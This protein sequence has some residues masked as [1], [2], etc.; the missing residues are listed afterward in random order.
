[1]KKWISLLLCGTLVL[2]SFLAAGT[3]YNNQ[4]SIPTSKNAYVPI[5]FGINIDVHNDGTYACEF[6]DREITVN[7]WTG[8]YQNVTVII[9]I[10]NAW[11]NTGSHKVWWRIAEYPASG[12][13]WSFLTYLLFHGAASPVIHQLLL[14]PKIISWKAA[15]NDTTIIYWTIPIKIA[16]TESFEFD[17]LV[18]DGIT[19][20][21][22]GKVNYV[23][24]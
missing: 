9:N 17:I 12:K 6:D 11:N 13:L 1:M 16:S 10:T 24:S 18:A 7:N 8:M 3:I 5:I 2:S 23:G 14:S 20:M 22:W 15:D 4:T 21:D 19:H